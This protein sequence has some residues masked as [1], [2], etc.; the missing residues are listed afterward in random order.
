M[1]A[2]PAFSATMA[3]NEALVMRIIFEDCLGFIRHGRTPFA[4][5]PTRPA[6]AAAIEQ[7]PARMPDRNK[8]VELLSPRYVAS[9]GEDADGRHC[10]V[11]VNLAAPQAGVPMRLGVP[12]AGFLQR[13]TRRA[14]DEGLRDALVADEFSPLATS[15]WS[16]P[17]TGHDRGPLRPVSMSVMATTPADAEG[18]AEAGLIVM[19]GPPGG[20]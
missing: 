8:A 3:P 16:E 9:W 2:P 15:T 10:Y 12:T 5:L 19:G 17:A 7:L 11:G 1:L 14:A 13:V 20:R 18:N 4:K 6:A